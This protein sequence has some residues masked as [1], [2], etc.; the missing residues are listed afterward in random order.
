MEVDGYPYL[1]C[2]NVVCGHPMWLPRSSRL[3]N[4]PDLSDFDNR[5]F[6]NYVCPA[7][8][9]V[10]DYRATDVRWRRARIRDQAHIAALYAA[11]LEFVC[12]EENCGIRTVIHKPM[13]EPL[14]AAEFLRES[15]NWAMADVRCLK[16]HRI[17]AL[18]PES[19]RFAN[20]LSV[21]N[22]IDS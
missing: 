6:E 19:K 15:S 20:M 5:Y 4:S 12:T 8:I 17:T 9:H 22:E 16:E 14:N 10:Y 18:P 2:K 13:I 1:A 7:C 11:L 21:P 3:K